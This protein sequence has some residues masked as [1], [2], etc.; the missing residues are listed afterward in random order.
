MMP[1]IVS[2]DDWQDRVDEALTVS[3]FDD[4]VRAR[5]S[6]QL[7]LEYYHF[8]DAAPG[9]VFTERSDLFNPRLT[10]FF[11]AQAGSQFYIFAQ[12]RLDRGFDASDEQAD[13]RLD[14]FAVRWTPWE[15]GRFNVQVGKFATVV[16][17]WTQRHL[18][19]E[20]PFINGP[21]IYDTMTAIY[22]SELPPSRSAFLEGIT[23]DK[24]EY[25][26]VLWGA[27][28]AS[29]I[30]VSGKLGKFDY[31]FEWKNAP[32]SSRP[33]SWNLNDIDLSHG[34][35]SGRVG[36][37]P[38]QAW[39]LGL[40]ASKGAYFLDAVE[41]ELPRGRDMN[42]YQQIVLGQDISY[43]WGH[44]Q[45]WAEV[46]EARF[47]VPH[48][49]SADVLGYYL[50]TKYKF[51]PQLFG[52]LRW[53]QMIYDE[54]ADDQGG[55]MPWGHDLWRIDVAMTYRFTPHT[56]LKLQYTTQH[57]DHAETSLSHMIAAQFTLRF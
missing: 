52:A 36:Y 30:A 44:W 3:A 19:W 21:L 49:G 46:F 55:T 2:A 5:L 10:M 51:T 17:N 1:L 6:G 34:T 54:V 40:S 12:G 38:D 8:S 22:D 14:E 18:S 4:Q 26:P 39:N 24:Y 11:D 13:T 56:Q 7:D 43:A 31:A 29:G 25:N 53:N 50:E 35:I 57:E 42:D 32:L 9:L 28:Y 45:F 27:S 23:E 33:E 48:V 37:R 20:N 15:D 41:D 47:Q 16:G